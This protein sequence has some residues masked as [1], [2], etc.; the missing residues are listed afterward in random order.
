MVCVGI[1]RLRSEMTFSVAEEVLNEMVRSSLRTLPLEMCGVVSLD[2]EW[3]EVTNVLQSEGMYCMDP[4]E[5]LAVW[6]P[7]FVVHSHVEHPAYP[8]RTDI[9]MAMH[10]LHII[11]SV[12]H[13]QVRAFS[14][15][16]RKVIER[17]LMVRRTT[18]RASSIWA[19]LGDGVAP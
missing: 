10:D 1:E 5:Q 15:V 8:S 12:S 11:V 19:R 6:P 7:L 4:D 13:R 9:E 17:P 3:K 2:G 14:I 18:R 16:D